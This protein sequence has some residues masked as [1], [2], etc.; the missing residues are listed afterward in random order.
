[1]EVC[2]MYRLLLVSTIALT[3]ARALAQE[4]PNEWLVKERLWLK[5]IAF[6]NCVRQAYIEYDSVWRSDGTASTY[7]QAGHYELGAY[8]SI[9]LMAKSYAQRVYDDSGYV[10][11]GFEGETLRIK[12]CLD[13]YNSTALDSL[14]IRLDRDVDTA[15]AIEDYLDYLDYLKR[16]EHKDKGDSLKQEN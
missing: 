4:L 2:L 13:L 16:K 8:D 7:F 6:C 9:D 15:R 3:S 11:G 5:N 14:I 10:Y 1:M 12:K